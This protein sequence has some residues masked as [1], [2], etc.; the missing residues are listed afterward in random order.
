MS[1]Y[2]RAT[3][4]IFLSIKGLNEVKSITHHISRNAKEVHS[5]FK[6]IHDFIL[7]GE[8]Y[9]ATP[10]TNSEITLELNSTQE[11][12]IKISQTQRSA[13]GMAKKA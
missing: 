8:D 3:D 11:L 7:T 10:S 4:K 9:H 6:Y 12:L 1:R 13:L 5:A 2:R